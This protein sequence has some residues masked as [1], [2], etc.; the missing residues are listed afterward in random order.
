MQLTYPTLLEAKKLE[1]LGDLIY[2]TSTNDFIFFFFFFFWFILQQ[3]TFFI[4]QFFSEHARHFWS[5]IGLGIEH[6]CIA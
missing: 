2:A 5:I 3:K 6:L 1:D 4:G